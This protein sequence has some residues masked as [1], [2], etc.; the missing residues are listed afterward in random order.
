MVHTG[1]EHSADTVGIEL[2]HPEKLRLALEEGC[3]VIAAHA[4]MSAFFDREDFFPSL[5]SLIRSFPN[6]YCDTAVLASMF[7]WRNLPRILETPEVLERTIH[8]SDFPFPS[9]PLVFW[10]RLSPSTVG[11]LLGQPNLLER[12]YRIKRGLGLPQSVFERGSELLE[13]SARSRPA[14]SQA[15]A[16]R[17]SSV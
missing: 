13:E 15:L 10:N 16:L 3:T 2:S 7:R 17:A 12:D 6:L 4:G 11:S 8:G 1:A 14:G 5:V 9:N